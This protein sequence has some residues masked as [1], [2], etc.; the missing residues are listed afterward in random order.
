MDPLLD[1]NVLQAIQDLP[2]YEKEAEHE[3]EQLVYFDSFD[4]VL[5]I[6]NGL[7]NIRISFYFELFNFQFCFYFSSINTFKWYFCAYVCLSSVWGISCSLQD[8]TRQ[9]SWV[10]LVCRFVSRQDCTWGCFHA[11]FV[12]VNLICIVWSL[13][14][15]ICISSQTQV[16][17]FNFCSKLHNTSRDLSANHITHRGFLSAKQRTPPAIARLLVSQPSE[18]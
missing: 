3:D 12:Q 18:L 15:V 7:R 11:R 4:Y 9:C 10:Y 14:T 8:F 13:V 2:V 17:Q 1:A 5:D 16:S 6:A